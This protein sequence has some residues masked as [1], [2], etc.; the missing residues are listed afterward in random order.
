MPKNAMTVEELERQMSSEPIS[1]PTTRSAMGPPSNYGLPYQQ[2]MVGT[3]PT[4]PTNH[5]LIGSPLTN[6]PLQLNG[7]QMMRGQPPPGLHIRPPV[8]ILQRPQQLG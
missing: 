2:L 7:R 4:P 6:S 3:P 1:V 5:T 8:T